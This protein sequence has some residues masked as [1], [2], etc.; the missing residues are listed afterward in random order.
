MLWTLAGLTIVITSG[1]V[2]FTSDPLRY[3]YSP[4]FPPEIICLLI[5]IIFN[6]TV[7]RK[8]AQ[9]KDPGLAG[10]LVG[11]ISLSCGSPSFSR[12]FFMRLH[13]VSEPPELDSGIQ[14]L[15]VACC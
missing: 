13:S 15:N 2:I 14:G 7:H 10:G 3:Y 1:L 12:D 8:V 11:A 9:S 5:A 4:R 6:Y